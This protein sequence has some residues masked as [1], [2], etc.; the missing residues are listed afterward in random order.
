MTDVTSAWLVESMLGRSLDALYP[1]TIRPR[2]RSL[3]EV[4]RLTSSG[5]FQDI[6]LTVNEGEI[7]GLAGLVGAG[8]SEVARSLFGIDP[9]ESG[10]VRLNGRPLDPKPWKAV[11]A[12]FG[13]LPED[14]GRD[15]LITSMSVKFNLSLAALGGMCRFGF[16]DAEAETNVASRLLRELDIRPARLDAVVHNLSGGNQQRVVLGK[17]LAIGPKLLILD[18]PTQ[19]VDVG[20]KAEIHRLIDDLPG[21]RRAHDFL[22]SA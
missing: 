14:R 10:S 12:G 19:G 8:R 22:R 3:L 2:G 1:R 13:L 20:A 21:R 17:W 7:V 15:G 4:E 5:K 6:S 9:F 16:I 18:E 11:E